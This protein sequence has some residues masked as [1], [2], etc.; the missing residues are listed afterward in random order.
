ME[1]I[2]RL[3]ELLFD[4]EL[5]IKELSSKVGFKLR[6]L[7]RYV[8]NERIPCL[9]NCIKLSEFFKCSI[10]YL[11]GLSNEDNY[12]NTYSNRTFIEIYDELLRDNQTNN[13]SVSLSLGIGRNQY[14]N[15]KKG[16]NPKIETLIT[17]SKHFHVSID[18]LIGKEY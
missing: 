5:E 7:Y 3:N 8:N 4:N 17:L 2:C 1:A 10:D 12:T 14:Y 16:V 6:V 15:W 18:Y 13:H 9:K 11:L